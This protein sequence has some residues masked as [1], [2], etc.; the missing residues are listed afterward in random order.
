LRAE[1]FVIVEGILA[2]YYEELQPLYDLRIFVDAP[3]DLCLQR[4]LARDV[5]ERGRTPESV[6]AQWEATV[7]PSA[8]LY[9]LPTALHADLVANGAGELEREVELVLDVMRRRTFVR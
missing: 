6:R 9:V 7:E 8:R 4:R 5:A 2:L 1:R 3:A